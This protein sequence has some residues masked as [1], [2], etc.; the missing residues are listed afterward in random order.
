MSASLPPPQVICLGEGLIDRIFHRYDANR[1]VAPFWQDCPG[2][3]PANVATGLVK[4][5]T[6]AGFVG[7]IGQDRAGHHLLEAL[8]VAG[9]N[10]SQVQIHPF[11]STRLV[12]VQ[13]DEQGDRHF[14]GFGQPQVDGYADTLLQSNTLDPA[15][16]RPGAVLVMGTLGLAH[17]ATQASMKQA[18]T[19]AQANQMNIVVDV[20]WRPKFWLNPQTA[21]QLIRQLIDQVDLVKMSQEEA[22]WLFQTDDADRILAQLPAVTAVVITAGPN[23]CHYAT[24]SANAAMDAFPVDCEDST[25]AGDAFLA[26]LIHYLCQ[27]GFAGLHDAD[28]LHRAIRYASAAG[29]LTTLRAGAMAAQPSGDE[30]SA[31]LYLHSNAGA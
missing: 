17:P 11:A 31:F 3:A 27:E 9:V 18:L 22:Y 4:L 30:V 5:G 13:R 7:C 26:G 23:G 12:L 2:G 14:V 20:N 25:G 8:K 29:A 28:K 24:A 15:W 16:F 21:P 19:W 1:S 6:P 10:D